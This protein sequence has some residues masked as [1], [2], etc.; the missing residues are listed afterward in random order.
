MKEKEK[1]E[2][3]KRIEDLLNLQSKLFSEFG[4]DKYNVFIF[5]S[6]P[7]TGYN[8]Q[9]SDV[10]VAVYT[11]DFELYKRIAAEIELYFWEKGVESDIFY[12]DLTIPA[13]FFVAPLK[14]QIQFTDYYPQELIDFKHV[15]EEQLRQIKEKIV[16]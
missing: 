12:I 14:A 7:T 13:P 9:T 10:D 16:A 8:E 2:A 5:G 4:E 3:L 15:C 6:Y 1:A 11:Q